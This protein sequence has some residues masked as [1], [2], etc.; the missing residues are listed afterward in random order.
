MIMI[1]NTAQ[2]YV[3]CATVYACMHAYHMYKGMHNYKTMQYCG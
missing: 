3:V 1:F 2:I